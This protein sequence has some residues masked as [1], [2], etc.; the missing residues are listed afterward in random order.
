MRPERSPPGAIHDLVLVGLGETHRHL[1]SHLRGSGETFGVTVVAPHDGRYGG[2]TAAMLAGA[3]SPHRLRWSPPSATQVITSRAIGCQPT[4]GRLWLADG[5]MMRYHRLSLNTG[6][7]RLPAWASHERPGCPRISSGH[8][9][10]QLIALRAALDAGTRTSI[11]I[12]GGSRSALEVAGGVAAT[13]GDCRVASVTLLWPGRDYSRTTRAALRRL[14]WVGVDVIPG[15]TA[16]GLAACCVECRDG[17]RFRADH[18]ICAGPAEPD[19][20]VLAMN[21]P[22][23]GPGLRVD[24]RLASPHAASVQ[25]TGAAA[26][27]DGRRVLP[28]WDGARQARVVLSALRGPARGRGVTRYATP[29]RPVAPDLGPVPGVVSG[30]FWL[31]AW[32]RWRHRHGIDPALAVAEDRDPDATRR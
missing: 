27:L 20:L 32:D 22:T 24:R 3:V 14:A 31:R 5:R 25:I 23:Y 21:L 11:V 6:T 19:P 30:T 4:H 29:S 26:S 18:V 2:A 9:A 7:R 8:S 28:G 13:A 16:S 10:M 15:A 12:A 1:L 17:R